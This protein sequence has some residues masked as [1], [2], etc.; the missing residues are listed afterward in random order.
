M[1]TL[2]FLLLVLVAAVTKADDLDVIATP[3][4][5]AEERG[6]AYHRL[7]DADF[8]SIVTK[9][10]HLYGKIKVS[11]EE[12]VHR[13]ITSD[14][15]PWTDPLKGEN[16]RIRDTLGWIWG[17]HLMAAENKGW[18][19]VDLVV[20]V[21]SDPEAGDLR[22]AALLD[23]TRRLQFNQELVEP[24]P[25]REALL[26]FLDQAARDLGQSLDTRLMVL[27]T[28]YRSGDPNQYFDLAIALSEK[29]D[30]LIWISEAFR[31]VIPIEGFRRLSVENQRKYLEHGFALLKQLDDGKTG[32]GYHLAADLGRAVGVPPVGKAN[33]P[34]VPDQSLP[35]YQGPNGLAKSFF[36]DTVNNAFKWWSAQTPVRKKTGHY[37]LTP[38]N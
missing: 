30:S 3:G 10:S 37:L 16:L 25:Q 13:G 19:I 1:R 23:L 4:I 34:F 9:L 35:K 27:K 29:K 21:A 36:Q 33:S 26:K 7:L 38:P 15:E 2:F 31:D 20:K 17:H 8:P 5:T 24:S 32:A 28:L 14:P 6:K 18:P 12:E 11:K 22:F